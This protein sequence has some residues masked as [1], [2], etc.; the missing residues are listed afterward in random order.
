MSGSFVIKSFVENLSSQYP[1][2]ASIAPVSSSYSPTPYMPVSY[3]PYFGGGYGGVQRQVVVSDPYSMAM[4]RAIDREDRDES[5]ASS[6]AFIGG[7]ATLVLSALAA[8]TF[9]GYFKAKKELKEAKNF[10]QNELQ[11][12]PSALRGRLAPIVSKHI[13]LLEDKVSYSRNVA[14][15][16]GTALVSAAGAFL[17]GMFSIHSLIT[18]A[19]IAGV[20]SAAFAIFSAVWQWA[21]QESMPRHMAL[22]LQQINLQLRC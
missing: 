18:V 9:S 5:R 22:D 6:A 21:N 12:M 19:I 14:V 8:F 11:Q 13:E 4:A 2:H 20:A 3:V 1:V 17:G 10:Q 16:S 15:A 7:I